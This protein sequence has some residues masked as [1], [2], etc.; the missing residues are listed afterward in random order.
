M[1]EGNLN[2][3]DLSTKW[4]RGT[5]FN[6]RIFGSINIFALFQEVS[7]L[8]RINPNVGHLLVKLK[9]DRTSGRSSH[10]GR[11]DYPGNPAL[12]CPESTEN[13]PNFTGNPNFTGK[14]GNRHHQPECPGNP[15]QPVF[16]FHPNRTDTG[17]LNPSRPDCPTSSSQP[18]FMG[19]TNQG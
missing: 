7:S 15:V 17:P 3:T 8:I 4:C 9:T 5:K 12:P 16:P 14:S 2:K 10:M 18:K 19:N 13:R 1:K 11:S 6:G